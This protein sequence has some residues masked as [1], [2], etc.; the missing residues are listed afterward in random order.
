MPILEISIMPI[1]TEETSFSTFVTK[2][3][4]IVKSHGL[5]YQVT[6]MSTIVEGP[7]DDLMSIAH[8]VHLLPL[9]S[10]ANRVITNMTIDERRDK[11]MDMSSM[12]NAV[13]NPL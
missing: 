11:D 9:Q 13:T 10:G 2:A 4:D 5:K 3:C 12:V 6:P 1:G 7:L 8:D